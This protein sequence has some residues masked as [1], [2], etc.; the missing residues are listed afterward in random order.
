M[1]PESC[2]EEARQWLVE[3]FGVE[4]AL[5]GFTLSVAVGSAMA[6][7]SALRFAEDDSVQVPRGYVAAGVEPTCELLHENNRAF[8][9]GMEENDRYDHEI[10]MRWRGE[11][12]SDR[13][14]HS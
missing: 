11:R 9:G 2:D 13:A 4:A 7:S 3:L 10:T 12:A 6:R 8:F 1:T 14:L 5:E